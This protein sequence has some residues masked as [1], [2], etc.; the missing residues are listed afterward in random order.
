MA[1]V[2]PLH[3]LLTGTFIHFQSMIHLNSKKL[4]SEK[5]C[6][7]P[8]LVFFPFYSRCKSGVNISGTLVSDVVCNKDLSN[9]HVI[10]PTTIDKGF[11]LLNR[12]TS[13]QPEGARTQGLHTTT[14]TTSSPRLAA[15][16]KTKVPVNPLNTGSHIGKTF[17]ATVY[18]TFSYHKGILN[19]L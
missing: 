19:N 3:S 17:A 11:S 6:L 15:T 2:S 12:I 7:L 16:H 14:T 9:T 13:R 1:R 5:C 10:R 4:S 18:D 8:T